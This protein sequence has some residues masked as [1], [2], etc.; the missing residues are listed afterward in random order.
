M[1]AWP[2][3]PAPPTRTF[4]GRTLTVKVYLITRG[5]GGATGPKI[6]CGDSVVGVSRTLPYS[7]T[8][9][10]DAMKEMLTIHD[11]V[12]GQSGLYNALAAS[13]LQ[14][15]SVAL[16]GGVATIRLSGTVSIAGD[17]DDANADA[18]ITSI[19]IGNRFIGHLLD[20]PRSSDLH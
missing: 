19:S 8:P 16:S 10:T 18:K 3:R 14:V 7:T 15:D 5:D 20:K 6:G 1:P 13:R 17:C 12:Y 4:T 2:A 11:Q 9:L